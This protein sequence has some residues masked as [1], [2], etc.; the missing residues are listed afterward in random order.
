MFKNIEDPK[1]AV[2][3]H[4]CERSLTNSFYIFCEECQSIEICVKCFADGKESSQHNRTHSFRVIEKLKKNLFDKEWTAYQEL[5]FL[6]ALG[7]FG[8][9]NWHYISEFI[10]EKNKEEVEEHFLT[11]Y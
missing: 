8:Y 6:E 10:G 7:I 9:G 1:K 4:F 5:A 2:F 11:C 3:C